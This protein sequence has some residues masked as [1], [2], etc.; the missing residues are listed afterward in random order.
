MEN[1][2]LAC[3]VTRAVHEARQALALVAGE[4][5]R[6]KTVAEH[7]EE[8][9]DQLNGI[10]RGLLS[11]SAHNA[12]NAASSILLLD[13]VSNNLAKVL[14]NSTEAAQRCRAGDLSDTTPCC[15]DLP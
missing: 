8:V 9:A 13:A 1:A 3:P 2:C 5:E 14:P 15:A 12:R 4:V 11:R 6:F 7:I 10:N